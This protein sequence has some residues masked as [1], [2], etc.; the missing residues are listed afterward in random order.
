M[1]QDLVRW[2]MRAQVSERS[3]WVLLSDTAF[4]WAEQCCV[5]QYNTLCLL[6]HVI[7]DNNNSHLQ[8]E[9]FDF[10]RHTLS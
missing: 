5:S 4:V 9:L 1:G 10:S 3:P 7:H 8:T 6:W 2:R